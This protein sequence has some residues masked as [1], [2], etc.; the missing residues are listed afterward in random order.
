MASRR[1]DRRL[2]AIDAERGTGSSGTWSVPYF[3]IGITGAM[4]IQLASA[5]CVCLRTLTATE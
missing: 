2:V 5:K 4:P 3:K 1:E